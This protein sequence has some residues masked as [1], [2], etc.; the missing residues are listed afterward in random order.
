M[1]EKPAGADWRA[2]LLLISS[3][4]GALLAFTSA[5][6]TLALTLF[7]LDEFAGLDAS[8]L[9]TLLAGSTLAAVG[10][11]FLPVGY[12]SLRR[13]RG[14]GTAAFVLPALRPWTWGLLPFL[15]LLAATLAS[16]FHDAPGALLYAP[17]LH[18]LAVALPLYLLARAAL[19]R[20]PLGSA[21]RAW[22]ALGSGMSLSLAVALTLEIMVIL[23]F[24][25]V[26][27]VYLAFNPE[28]VGAIERLAGQVQHAPNLESLLYAFAPVVNHP[29]TLLA[30]LLF[31]SGFVPLIEEFSKSLGV[32]LVSGRLTSPA[33]GFAMGVLGGAG[34]ALVESLSASMN[35]DDTWAMTFAA[36]AFSGL[37][38]VLASGLTG[39]G[40]AYARLEKRY[41][42]LAGLFVLGV[43]VHAVWN[44]GAVLTA[45]GGLRVT[46][47]DPE[48]DLLGVLLGL[49]G[50]ATIFVMAATMAVGLLVLNARLRPTSQGAAQPAVQ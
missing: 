22:G 18:F 33:Q 8:P 41:A 40:V 31:L 14:L 32:W 37:M 50:L 5:L 7:G 25:L 36:R 15:W 24:L 29:L 6:A 2:I 43:L 11:L 19:A 38:H 34:F 27:G 10:L 42:R 48:I 30:A 16:L 9:S 28:Q 35:P 49:V 26:L 12:Y 46:L 13:L 3:L 39:M 1:D 23:L 47:A 20:I 4:G 44:G 21:L 45:V 17:A